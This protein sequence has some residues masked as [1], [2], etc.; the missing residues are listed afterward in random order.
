MKTKKLKIR[1]LKKGDKFVFYGKNK[2][3]EFHGSNIKNNNFIIKKST[4]QR[5]YFVTNPDAL[6]KITPI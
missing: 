5:N 4:S 1:Q 2:I 6:V 3:W